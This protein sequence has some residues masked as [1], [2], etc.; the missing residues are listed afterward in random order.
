MFDSILRPPSRPA[1][2]V[3]SQDVSI[4][5]TDI[6]LPTLPSISLPGSASMRQLRYGHQLQP[7]RFPPRDVLPQQVERLRLPMRNHDR[8]SVT[9]RPR[10][11][12][13]PACPLRTLPPV[14]LHRDVSPRR[15]H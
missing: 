10:R 1:A 4:P 7:G 12:F 13:T 15:S 6:V 5:S 9:L 14:L 2:A 8:L 3:S 11:H